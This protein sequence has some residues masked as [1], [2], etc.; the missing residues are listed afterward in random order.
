MK[1]IV[2]IIALIA[3]SAW[4]DSYLC[5]DMLRTFNV[6]PLA[7]PHGCVVETGANRASEAAKPVTMKGAM[8]TFFAP[9]AR[10]DGFLYKNGVESN[11]TPSS[12]VKQPFIM[13][14]AIRTFLTPLARLDGF[15]YEFGTTSMASEA[16]KA[17]MVAANKPLSPFGWFLFFIW[18]VTFLRVV[19]L[20][21][22]AS[23][24]R[25]NKENEKNHS[26]LVDVI[27][28]LGLELQMTQAKVAT[29]EA[30]PKPP[31]EPKDP[32]G[33]SH[34][35]YIQDDDSVSTVASML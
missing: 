32:S 21:D 17:W 1:C 13:K 16:P 34:Y 5:D 24:N 7:C 4:A 23:F 25:F 26:D 12:L 6:P 33:K 2:F 19:F 8:F 35:R 27:T 28:A 11:L 20:L 10:P 29:I 31:S 22:R 14:D 15:L 18:M 9:L 3:G 30:R